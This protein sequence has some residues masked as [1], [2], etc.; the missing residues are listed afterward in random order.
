MGDQRS[1]CNC[2]KLRAVARAVKALAMSAGPLGIHPRNWHVVLKA[3]LGYNAE[4]PILKGR[5]IDRR[6]EI[7]WWEG[8]IEGFGGAGDSDPD[9]VVDGLAKMVKAK[10]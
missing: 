2:A 10:R 8:E 7:F 6:T 5:V 9:L 1:K 3:M 4:A